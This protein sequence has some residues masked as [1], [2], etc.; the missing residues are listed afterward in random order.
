[1][2][3]GQVWSSQKVWKANKTAWGARFSCYIAP[4]RITWL[5]CSHSTQHRCSKCRFCDKSVTFNKINQSLKRVCCFSPLYPTRNYT[6]YSGDK[7]QICFCDLFN[8]VSQICHRIHISNACAHRYC[9]FLI[10]TVGDPKV[11]VCRKVSKNLACKRH[12]FQPHPPPH[13]TPRFVDMSAF[14]VLHPWLNGAI[15]EMAKKQRV[16]HQQCGGCPGRPYLLCALSTAW[17]SQMWSRKLNKFINSFVRLP[18]TRNPAKPVLSFNIYHV[19][20][21]FI[22]AYL[23]LTN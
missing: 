20:L 2:S 9:H 8:S 10:G 18:F 4:S 23:I 17:Q 14:E 7:Q 6:W 12:V 5:A 22:K 16:H 19:V 3:S 13:S 1:M 21:L 11:C 15:S